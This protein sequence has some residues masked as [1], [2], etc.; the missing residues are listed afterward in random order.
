MAGGAF[1]VAELVKQLGLKPVGPD[2]MRV[3]GDIQPVLAVGQLDD[4]TPQHVPASAFVGIAGIAVLLEVSTL[5]LQ[6]LSAGGLFVDW[7]SYSSAFT[8]QFRIRAAALAAAQAIIVPSNASNETVASVV[9]G[10]SQVPTG[11]PL[12]GLLDQRS[13]FVNFQRP[14]YVPKGMFFSIE[15][16]LVNVPASM[17]FGW[18]EVPAAPN[19]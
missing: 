18:R 15:G 11:G 6:C 4:L 12:G 19:L 13:S 2:E 1:N 3:R 9:R 8:G 16:R 10:G 5:E 17:A 7:L 14:I